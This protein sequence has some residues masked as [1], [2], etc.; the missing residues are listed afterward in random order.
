MTG[1]DKE[2][3]L[4][5][6]DIIDGHGTLRDARQVAG[7]TINQAAKVLAWPRERILA[8]EDGAEAT[9]A[10]RAALCEAYDVKGWL[11]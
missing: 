1:E 10:E 5:L 11:P 2:R 7:L 4:N 6:F 8:L 9:K 3:L